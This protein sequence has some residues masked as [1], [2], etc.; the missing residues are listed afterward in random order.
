MTLPRYFLHPDAPKSANAFSSIGSFSIKIKSNPGK[1]PVRAYIDFSVGQ[2][3][4]LPSSPSAIS[5]QSSWHKIPTPATTSSTFA[6]K[7]LSE[8]SECCFLRIISYLRRNSCLR[9]FSFFSAKNDVAVVLPV[10]VG[11]V[12][13]VAVPLW[14]RIPD[15]ACAEITLTRDNIAIKGDNTPRDF[16]S[17]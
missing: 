15:P 17:P 8:R 13:V 11:P 4:H 7:S 1:P 6:W 12:N 3:D 9:N 16:T 14:F 2:N 5:I 10:P